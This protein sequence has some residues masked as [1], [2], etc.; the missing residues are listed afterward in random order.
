MDA[1]IT[2]GDTSA[3]HSVQ[4]S[5]D[6]ELPGL[7]STSVVLA[8]ASGRVTSRV[9]G[10]NAQ[11][12]AA[13]A[14]VVSD[15]R[16]SLEWPL[17]LRHYDVVEV[18][19]RPQWCDAGLG[20]EGDGQQSDDRQLTDNGTAEQCADDAR[21]PAAQR[22]P[23]VQD[24]GNCSSVLGFIEDGEAAAGQAVVGRTTVHPSVAGDDGSHSSRD[25]SVLAAAVATASPRPQPFDGYDVVEVAEL[26]GPLLT[27]VP[28]RLP[29][30]QTGVQ[31]VTLFDNFPVAAVAGSALSTVAVSGTDDILACASAAV[32]AVSSIVSDDVGAVSGSHSLSF[33]SMLLSDDDGGGGSGVGVS[34]GRGSRLPTPPSPLP[35]PPWQSAGRDAIDSMIT[36]DLLQERPDSTVH[37]DDL[38]DGADARRAL[39]GL[40]Y[41]VV[42]AALVPQALFVSL[43]EDVGAAQATAAVHETRQS[44]SPVGQRLALAGDEPMGAVA[45]RV[46]LAVPPRRASLDVWLGVGTVDIDCA[47]P[48]SPSP[49]SPVPPSPEVVPPYAPDP[50]S[51]LWSGRQPVS[52]RLSDAL[53]HFWPCSRGSDGSVVGGNGQDGSAGGDCSVP[54]TTLLPVDYDADGRGT[55]TATSLSRRWN[56]HALPPWS[57][58]A[59]S[60]PRSVVTTATAAAGTLT[61]RLE[62]EVRAGSGLQE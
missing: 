38:S 49:P 11:F 2:S 34:G 8:P 51:E 13:I 35:T 14:A 46:D 29:T 61:Q 26:A 39:D 10:N 45:P 27:T 56:A 6:D 55:H 3:A 20:R 58:A 59:S 42:E 40:K 12:V 43:V 36:A 32:S 22:P 62:D 5:D 37:H 33:Q 21:G 52:G 25:D 19:E 24:S 48:S 31:P 9:D 15:A 41:D 1:S 7:E 4:F 28:P 16:P 17:S 50:L 23:A 57:S 60:R 18:A 53:A 44:T 47:P 54:R 30:T